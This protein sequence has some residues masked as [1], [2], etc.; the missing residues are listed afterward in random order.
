MG[1]V[2][3]ETKKEGLRSV[4]RARALLKC[5]ARCAWF[6]CS[7]AVCGSTVNSQTREDLFHLAQTVTKH[8]V[9]M[10]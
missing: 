6:I 9:T 8:L 5:T 2:D 3:M 1:S 7:N 10:G 4:H